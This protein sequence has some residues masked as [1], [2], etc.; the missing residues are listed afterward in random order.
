MNT[1]HLKSA[2]AAVMMLFCLQASAQM[3]FIEKY[4]DNK[5]ATYVYVGK[6][7][8]KMLGAK[9]F[10]TPGGRDISPIADK[11]TSLQVVTSEDPAT[12]AEIKDDLAKDVRNYNFEVLLKAND[13]GEKVTIYFL[14]GKKENYVLISANEEEETSLIALSGTFTM[15]DIEILSKD[16]NKKDDEDNE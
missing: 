16:S 4:E 7:L 6:A 12:I 13:E 11:L 15:S 2:L 10:S 3:E 9:N 5:N 1:R 14:E 8:F